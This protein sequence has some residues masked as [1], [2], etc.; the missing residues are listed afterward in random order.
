MTIYLSFALLIICLTVLILTRKSFYEKREVV[1]YFWGDKELSSGAGGYLLWSTELSLN[2]L[3]YHTWLGY[4]IGIYSIFMQMIF[5]FGFVLLGHFVKKGKFYELAN[6]DTLHGNIGRLYGNRARI[7]A[8]IASL[9]TFITFSA[10]EISILNDFIKISLSNATDNL[11]SFIP[12]AILF[13]AFFYTIRGGITYNSKIN[14]ATGRATFIILLGGVILTIFN[15]E[16]NAIDASKWQPANLLSLGIIAFISNALFSLFWQISDMSTWQNLTAVSNNKK[17][18]ILKALKFSRYSILFAPGVVGTIFGMSLANANNLTESN[19]LT[20]FMESFSYMPPIVS[21]IITVLILII[22]LTASMTMIDGQLL[23]SSKLVVFDLL[24]LDDA[25]KLLTGEKKAD[26]VKK[27]FKITDVSTILI[28]V[29]IIFIAILF[30]IGTLS[31]F[32]MVYV[33]VIGQMALVLPAI[34]MLKGKEKKYNAFLGIS[35][36]IIGGLIPIFIL[37]IF[38]P[39][40]EFL[41]INT[42]VIIAPLTTFLF[43][44]IGIIYKPLETRE[45]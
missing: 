42:W 43:S 14:T 17:E 6:S 10:W 38:V 33:A 3:F 35:F 18:G 7:I 16:P 15:F 19:I 2:G 22:F 4:T 23:A 29:F 37:K 25:N 5:V 32:E 41:G 31:L 40:P 34:Y 20:R 30:A 45:E 1:K 24:K 44:A 36:G 26:D 27:I 8:V 12:L 21:A 39:V 28:T 9:V 13:I 11:I